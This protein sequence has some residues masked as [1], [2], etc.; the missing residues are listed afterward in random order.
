[1]VQEG[2]D[3]AKGPIGTE[4][5]PQNKWA[6][7]CS[8]NTYIHV[9]IKTLKPPTHP[10]RSSRGALHRPLSR[11]SPPTRLAHAVDPRCQIHSTEAQRD[12]HRVAAAAATWFVRSTERAGDCVW[13]LIGTMWYQHT[14]EANALM[15]CQLR[16]LVDVI[17]WV[18]RAGLR[19]CETKTPIKSVKPL[20]AKRLD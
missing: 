15:C 20:P 10:A 7:E 11:R 18:E 2:G 3:N 9:C 16:G 19:V 6:F 13:R 14:Q 12:N 5:L 8:H 1:M 17:R 4:E